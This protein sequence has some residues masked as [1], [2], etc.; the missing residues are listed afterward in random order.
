LNEKL[1]EIIDILTNYTFGGEYD[2]AIE[3]HR[4]V[5]KEH[6]V[7]DTDMLEVCEVYGDYITRR[8]YLDD[9]IHDYYKSVIKSV[10]NV[11]ETYK[12]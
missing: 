4:E 2:C 9:F 10:C 1:Y 8:T 7:E 3:N 5:L 11:I 6:N 12:E